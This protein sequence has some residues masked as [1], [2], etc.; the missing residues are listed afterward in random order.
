MSIILKHELEI[1]DEQLI[2]LPKNFKI[3]KVGLQNGKLF[4]W[5]FNERKKNIFTPICFRIITTGID[6]DDSLDIKHIDTIIYPDR[7]LVY[8][9]FIENDI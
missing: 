3:L 7:N 8:H 5:T 1:I 9:I 6:I 2:S 4:V